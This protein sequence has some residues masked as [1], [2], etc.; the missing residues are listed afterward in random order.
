MLHFKGNILAYYLV[1]LFVQI[2]KEKKNNNNKNFDMAICKVCNTNIESEVITCDGIC[3]NQFHLTCIK[4]NSIK[5]QSMYTCP[6][7]SEIKPCHVLRILQQ[8]NAQTAAVLT[9]Q[10]FIAEKVNSF[11]NKLAMIESVSEDYA[12]IFNKLDCVSNVLSSILE[13]SVNIL[14]FNRS[15]NS[16]INSISEAVD[17][18]YTANT[19]ANN[20]FSN[21][22]KVGSME[23]SFKSILNSIGQIELD[24]KKCS[25]RLKT[26]TDLVKEIQTDIKGITSKP[27]LRKSSKNLSMTRSLEANPLINSCLSSSNSVETGNASD[28]DSVTIGPQCSFDKSNNKLTNAFVET[29]AQNIHPQ[30]NTFKNV[31]SARVAAAPDDPLFFVNSKATDLVESCA[32]ELIVVAPRACIFISRLA[33]DTTEK[34]IIDYISKQNMNLNIEEIKCSKLKFNYDRKIA[35]FKIFI[36]RTH[37][38]DILSPGFWPQFT[39]VHEFVSRSKSNNNNFVI[40]Q[41]DKKT[42]SKN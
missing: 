19:T 5:F 3:N 10:S 33:A 13:N 6:E 1:I 9:D 2:Q 8:M 17:E 4:R 42:A 29:H 22:S 34:G 16:K 25:S 24:L 30:E 12:V 27:S 21:L 31:T 35:S 11:S 26:N 36:P 37:L 39:I 15:L 18:F 7:C 23:P 40:E 28:N 14:D 38:K 20:D 41:K 32:D